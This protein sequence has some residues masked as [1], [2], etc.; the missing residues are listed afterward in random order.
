MAMSLSLAVTA[1]AAFND[2]DKIVNTEAVDMCVALNIINGRTNG[3]F[4]PAGNVTRAEAAKMICIALNGGKE[5]VLS[6]SATPVFA[7]IAGHWAAK[8]IEYCTSL[9]IVA[10][11]GAG[12]FN[13]NGNVK[14]VELA[15]MLLIALGY[16]AEHGKFLGANWDTNVNV[17]ASQKDLYEGLEKIKESHSSLVIAPIFCTRLSTRLRRLRAFSGLRTGE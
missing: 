4:D 11:D 12:K 15:K 14:A 5:P 2:Q 17:V 10:G 13:P 16:N 9:G 3:D 6:A 1:G 8:Y 7:D